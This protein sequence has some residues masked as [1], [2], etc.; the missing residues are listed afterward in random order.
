MMATGN[1]RVRHQSS[2]MRVVA[3]ISQI[4]TYV[5]SNKRRLYMIR[6][7]LKTVKGAD[8]MQDVNSRGKLHPLACGHLTIQGFRESKDRTRVIGGYV[9]RDTEILV[10]G[11]GPAG[12][13]AAIAARKKGF[14]VTVA[15]GAKPPI[16][17]ACGEGL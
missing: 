3:S 5:E 6:L 8:A 9:E 11:G 10:I 17:K 14:E 12:L 7:F 15:D 13:A 4:N 2:R 1:I 16:D